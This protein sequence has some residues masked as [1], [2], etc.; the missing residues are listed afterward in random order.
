VWEQYHRRRRRRN[1]LEA[2]VA[3]NSEESRQPVP[4]PAASDAA[5]AAESAPDL[6]PL[7]LVLDNA[8]SVP[9]L[10]GRKLS[11]IRFLSERIE[12]D[13]SGVIIYTTDNS[14]VA[15]GLQRFRYPDAGS[16]D[17][18][19]GL[20]G[21]SVEAAR[22]APGE[23]LELSFGQDRQLIVPHARSRSVTTGSRT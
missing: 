13:F 3:G 6:P 21:A 12:L 19:C 23:R 9:D 18:L 11:S 5:L 16:R 14:I 1:K 20:I 4:K 2:H 17:A 15:T 10:S 7:R 22:T 8:L